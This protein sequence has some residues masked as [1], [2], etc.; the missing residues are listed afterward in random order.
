MKAESWKRL[1]KAQTYYEAQGFRY[2]DASWTVPPEIS[3]ITKPK[4]TKDF[5]LRDKVLV[6][7]A[8]QSF[9][10]VYNELDSGLYYAITPCFRNEP[11]DE[12]HQEG[13]MK[14]E[15]F[16]KDYNTYSLFKKLARRFFREQLNLDPLDL[17]LELAIRR[18]GSDI[19]FK[20]IELGSYGI[21]LF[22]SGE[23]VNYPDFN[24][25][26]PCWVY[27]TGLAEPRFTKALEAELTF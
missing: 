5:Y 1:A 19:L 24:L 20:G 17:D 14:L 22:P 6:G 25:N 16:S 21:R 18:Y 3:A 10:S 26:M 12:W 13:F 9:L 2:F 4:N 8:E 15:L 23:N 27:G 11:I 7:S